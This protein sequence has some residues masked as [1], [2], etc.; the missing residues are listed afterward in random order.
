[1][2]SNRIFPLFQVVKE[3]NINKIKLFE[4]IFKVYLKNKFVFKYIFGRLKK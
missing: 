1:M 2:R 4:S 3:V